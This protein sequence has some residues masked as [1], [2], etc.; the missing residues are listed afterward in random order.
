MKSLS[1]S[2]NN[3]SL[4]NFIV[5][6]W[7]SCVLGALFSFFAASVV[8]SGWP[9]GLIPNITIPFT[10]EGDGTFYAMVAQ[11]SIEG[12]I[13]DLSRNGYPFGGAILDHPI[14]DLGNLAII[15]LLG[16]ITGSH[17]AVMNL[18]FLLSFPVTFIAS[19]CVLRSFGAARL[20]A[21]VTATLFAFLPFH[22][23]RI[24]HSFFPGFLSHGTTPADLGFWSGLQYN[25]PRASQRVRFGYLLRS[26]RL[27]SSK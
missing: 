17:A 24:N 26:K 27:P 1:S 11:R 6:E 5:Q 18:F 12:S 13:F 8:M 3:A 21:V 2:F 15:K 23:Q 16:L 25:Q 22:F 7:R 14:P 4:A 10:Y 19:F 20:S 9:T